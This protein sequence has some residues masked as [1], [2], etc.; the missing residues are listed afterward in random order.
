MSKWAD[1]WSKYANEVHTVP[2]D[3]KKMPCTN[4]NEAAFGHVP[5]I[6]CACKPTVSF[7]P[8]GDYLVVSHRDVERGGCTHDEHRETFQ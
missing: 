6:E 3:P 4:L 7:G 1:I 5:F 2:L 8:D